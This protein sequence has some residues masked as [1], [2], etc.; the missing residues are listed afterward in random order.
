MGYMRIMKDLWVEKGYGE[1]GLT[2]QNLPDQVA[3]VEK[4]FGNVTA[5]MRAGIGTGERRKGNGRELV[6]EIDNNISGLQNANFQVLQEDVD[7]HTEQGASRVPL[8]KELAP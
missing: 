5:T 1:L 8:A 6:S 3:S 2:C 7:F 4:N